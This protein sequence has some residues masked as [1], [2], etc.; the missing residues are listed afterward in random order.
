M[1]K[2]SAIDWVVKVMFYIFQSILT[3]ERIL[4]VLMLLMLMLMLVMLVLLM[5]IQAATV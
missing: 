3:T 5:V 4:L 1:G 2:K